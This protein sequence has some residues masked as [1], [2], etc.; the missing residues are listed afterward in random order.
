MVMHVFDANEKLSES[1]ATTVFNLAKESIDTRGLFAIAISGGSLPKV[2]F[3]NSVYQTS[4][5]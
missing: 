5:N 4:T 2:K 3:T 1:V